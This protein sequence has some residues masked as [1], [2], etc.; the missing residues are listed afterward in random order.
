MATEGDTVDSD[1]NINLL[2]I[3]QANDEKVKKAC[4]KG[5]F[6]SLFLTKQLKAASASDFGQIRWYPLMMK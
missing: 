5:T 1:L 2:S 3:L 6:T 4:L